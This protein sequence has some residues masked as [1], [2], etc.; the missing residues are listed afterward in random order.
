MIDL[1]EMALF[2]AVVE[3]GSFVGA[4]RA[5]GIP[6]ST[7]SRKVAGLEER[8]GSRLLHRTTRTVRPTEIGQ[9]Y[10]QKTARIIADATEADLLVQS[11]QGS[12]V[13]RLRVTTTLLFA[14][15]F[16]GPLLPEFH[17]LYPRVELDLQAMDRRV[18]LIAE[19]FD[20]AIRAGEMDDSSL[21][22][23]RL[24]GEAMLLCASPSYLAVHG[25]PQ[26]VSELVHHRCVVMGDSL[27]STW[28][29]HTPLGPESV[30]VRG[31][32]TVND[33]ELAKEGALAGMGIA[34]VPRFLCEEDLKRGSLVPVLGGC[35][36]K[37]SPV[38]VVYPSARQLSTKVR[39]FVDFVVERVPPQMEK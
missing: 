20:V 30:V 24:G 14:R 11:S 37:E 29:F 9:R 10:Y 35:G 25:V 16:L 13:G 33:I 2:S 31:I 23:R 6:K 5:L 36:V 27:A 7:L 3:Q 26:T 34:R 15:L 38:Y 39:S 32:L 21:V 18:D 12:P 28:R 17:R 4:S 1:N 22:A 8:L 19:G